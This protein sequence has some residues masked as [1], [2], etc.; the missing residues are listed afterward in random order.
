M[1]SIPSFLLKRLYV[2]G[3][4]KNTPGGFEFTL[5]NG[6]GSGYAHKMHP[7]IV[8]IKRYMKSPLSSTLTDARLRSQM[9]RLRI[10]SLLP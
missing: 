10:H 9:L 7:L 1:V 4:L 6:L 5:N 3:S 2:K 8:T